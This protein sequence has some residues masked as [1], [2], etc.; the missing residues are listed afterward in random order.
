MTIT[1][2]SWVMDD[3]QKIRTVRP[4]RWR[5]PLSVVRQDIEQQSRPV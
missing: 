2:H 4:N 1:I 3:M 5:R